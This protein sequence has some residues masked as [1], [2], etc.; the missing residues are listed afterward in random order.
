MSLISIQV[1]IFSDFVYIQILFF[2]NSDFGGVFP[3][4]NISNEIEDGD[5]AC[6]EESSCY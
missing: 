4:A 3:C 6:N 5:V 2:A 1:G